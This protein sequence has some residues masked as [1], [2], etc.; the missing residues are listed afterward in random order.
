V[1]HP[2]K[3]PPPVI[4]RY[5][6]IQ[7][8]ALREL[9]NVASGTAATALS[10]MVGREI[11]LSVP[12][13]LAL[14]LA[15]AVEAAGD[16]AEVTTAVALPVEGDLEALV[17]LL[18]DQDAARILCGLLGV[19]AGTEWGDSALQEIGNI[20]GA[21]YLG[22][23]GSMTGHS[24]LPTPPHVMTDL[25]GAIVASMLAQTAGHADTALVLDSEL[26]VAGEPCAIS[27]MLLPSAGGAHDLLAPLGLAEAL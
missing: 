23:L 25:L 9:A 17:L 6:D 11:G 18:I 8:D 5:T 3:E 12:M 14:P 15:D 13:A 21:S 10:Q 7:L 26:D 19:E 16:P 27:F 22:A 2:D 24:L 4:P 1:T 20:L